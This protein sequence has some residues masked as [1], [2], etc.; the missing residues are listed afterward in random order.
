MTANSGWTFTIDTEACS[1]HG[2]CYSL[3]PQGFSADEFGYG[4]PSGEAQPD[5][6]RGDMQFIVDSCPEEAISIVAA[7]AATFEVD[8]ESM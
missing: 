2:R 1:G 7:D 8:K 4:V 3:A 5:D 6:A